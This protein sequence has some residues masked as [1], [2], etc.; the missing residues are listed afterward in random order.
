[1]AKLRHIAL[2][3]SDADATAKFYREAFDFTEVG[4]VDHPLGYAI[5]LSDGT[6]N[7]TVVRFKGVDQL[8]KGM[9][10]TGLHHFGFLVDDVDAAS[11]KLESLGAACFMPRPP[12]DVVQTDG[13]EV[14][15]RGPD[16]V[17][18]DLCDH[19]WP[20]SAPLNQAG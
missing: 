12:K 8:G 19:P 10:F 16:G 13:F 9:D 11:K 20:G 14:K 17:V 4:R 15:H 5:S 6:I 2:A 7:L 1:M 3:T 18:I